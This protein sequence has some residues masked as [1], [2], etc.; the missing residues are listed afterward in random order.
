MATPT[1]DDVAGFLGRAE[2]AKTAQLAE[3]H[4][5]IVTRLVYDYT[6]GR[7]FDALTDIPNESIEAVIV[8]AT[9][10]L[11]QN[12]EGIVTESMGPASIRRTVFD[13]FSIA[14]RQL[15]NSYRRRTA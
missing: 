2:D 4:L 13:G 1:G 12:P 6:R 9:A 8:A 5:P 11:T 7:G 10:R 15:L 3:K 14:E